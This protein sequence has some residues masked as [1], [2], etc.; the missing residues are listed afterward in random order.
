MSHTGRLST[1]CV[2]CL[3][4]GS[5]VTRVDFKRVGHNADASSPTSIPHKGHK[6][7]IGLILRPN[8]C[9]IIFK[10]Y[11]SVYISSFIHADLLFSAG[12]F[13]DTAAKFVSGARKINVYKLGKIVELFWIPR[14]VNC[15]WRLLGRIPGEMCVT[16]CDETGRAKVGLLPVSSHKQNKNLTQTAGPGTEDTHKPQ[17]QGHIYL[18]TNF[19]LSHYNDLFPVARYGM[20]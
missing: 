15:R 9:T 8:S 6:I 2:N 1:K 18:F 12:T 13:P 19:K 3:Q 4:A 14:D 10:P 16:R 7:Q 11:K 17:P 5:H 20:M